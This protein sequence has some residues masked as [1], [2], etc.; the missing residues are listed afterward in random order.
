[1]STARSKPR[2]PTSHDVAKLAGVSQPTVSVV[3][4]GRAREV[5][6]SKITEDRVLAAARDLSYVPNR[7]MKSIRSGRSGIL[8]V[9]GPGSQWSMRHSYWS[10]VIA[11]LHEGAALRN[12]ELL[13]FAPHEGRSMEDTLSR[14]LNGLVDGLIV[15]PG[16]DNE[17]LDRLIAASIPLVVVGDPYQDVVT[18]TIDNVGS[19][20]YLFD[21]LYERGHRKF[22]YARVEDPEGTRP[23]PRLAAEIRPA[24]YDEALR[25][26]GLDPAENPQFFLACDVEGGLDTVL[27]LGATALLCHNDEWAYPLLMACERRGIRVPE[28]L[29]LVGFDGIPLPFA[30]KVVTTMRSPIREMGQVAIDRLIAIVEGQEVEPLT[31]LPVSFVMGETT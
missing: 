5:G 16:T 13:F 4:S 20:H 2:R 17:V 19:V 24:T 12:Q 1:M 27:S 31:T 25:R 29:A 11:S 8:G 22:A 10:E 30:R 26:H 9:F 18:V 23:Y 15:Q 21:H 7:L 6:I 3:F 14:M 28:D